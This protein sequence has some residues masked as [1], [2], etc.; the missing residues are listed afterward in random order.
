MA[1]A[2]M[3]SV[4]P[5]ATVAGLS[6]FTASAASSP[7]RRDTVQFDRPALFSRS[8]SEVARV[9]VVVIVIEGSDRIS[10]SESDSTYEL[11]SSLPTA[12]ELRLRLRLRLLQRQS[13]TRAVQ[14]RT[15]SPMATWK[16][17][18]LKTT[19]AALRPTSPPRLVITGPAS[20]RV[21]LRAA[22]DSARLAGARPMACSSS[23]P[24]T[25]LRTA[26]S[27][28]TGERRQAGP[29]EQL[30]PAL[31]QLQ[32]PE[33]DAGIQHRGCHVAGAHGHVGRV[34][35]SGGTNQVGQ[36]LLRVKGVQGF[37]ERAAPHGR[38]GCRVGYGAERAPEDGIEQRG[39]YGAPALR[40]AGLGL[41]GRLDGERA[42]P[43]AEEDK[44]VEG[45]VVSCCRR[46]GN[47]DDGRPQQTQDQ[48][49]MAS[50][51][52]A[53]PGGPPAGGPVRF[54]VARQALCKD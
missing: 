43:E 44:R 16:T 42:G 41:D 45:R 21:T 26:K 31:E 3:P 14:C 48:H 54:L 49:G 52:L 15:P 39:Q 53:D 1:A 30:G 32:A 12:L 2:L 40:A 51:K 33:D 36:R 7:P 50:S 23:G 47:A 17:M 46:H 37:F 27:E 35:A 6:S 24:Q 13:A 22:N 19:M 25:M 18:P 34:L 11:P 10:V 28:L 38:L 8:K 9:V 4:M 5:V 29:R 20:A